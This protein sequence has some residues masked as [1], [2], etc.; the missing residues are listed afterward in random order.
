MSFPF[1][2][3]FSQLFL[4][5]LS[6]PSKDVFRFIQHLAFSNP[7]GSLCHSTGKVIDF[8]AVELIQRNLSRRQ[9]FQIESRLSLRLDANDLVLQLAKTE[10]GFRQE[11]ARTASRIE[12]GQGRQLVMKRIQPLILGR[13]RFNGANL[14]QFVLEIIKEQ[15]VDHLVDVLDGRVVHSAFP[16]CHRIQRRLENRTENG[17]T[18]PTPV[19]AFACLIKQKGDHLRR[20]IGNF[21]GLGIGKQTAVDVWKCSKLSVEISVALIDWSIEHFEQVQN[22]TPNIARAIFVRCDVVMEHALSTEDA[23]IFGVQTEHQAHAQNVQTVL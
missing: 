1:G 19:K 7:K 4:N 14:S 22:G 17:R 16:A 10:I 15:G 11:I 23:G 21:K 13:Q 6:I 20:E 8:D 5:A 18:D 9:A 12:E 2:I 3:K